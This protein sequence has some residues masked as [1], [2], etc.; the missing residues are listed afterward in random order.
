[1]LVS[2]VLSVIF[3]VVAVFI[4]NENQTAA[5]ITLL[6]WPAQGKLGSILVLAFALGALCGIASVLPAY[7]S[8]TW[9]LLRSRRKIEEM[10]RGV[11][12]MPPPSVKEV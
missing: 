5:H 4:A 11:Q 7:L 10:E 3:A 8:K 2:L 1:M 9:A 12:T 6:G